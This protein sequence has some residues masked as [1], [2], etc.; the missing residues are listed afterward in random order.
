[1]PLRQFSNVTPAQKVGEYA[2]WTRVHLQ[3]R[4]ANTLYISKDRHVLENP[5][6][7]GLQQGLTI[8]QPAGIV[9][10]VWKGELWGL[11]SAAS[12]IVDVEDFDEV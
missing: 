2:R 12:T 8:T 9:S 10:L 6:P 7:N 3:S 4:D 1:M 11:G 5:G